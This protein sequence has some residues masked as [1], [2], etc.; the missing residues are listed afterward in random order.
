MT[1]QTIFKT[2]SE[3]QQEFDKKYITASEVM[4]ILQISRAGFLYQ[5]RA[6]KL[7]NAILVND[8]RVVIWLRAEIES[9]VEQWRERRNL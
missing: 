3:A 5:R 8:G 4:D 7:P 2:N 9:I 1:L 6:G